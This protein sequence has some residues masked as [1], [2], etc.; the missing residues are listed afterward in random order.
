MTTKSSIRK[1]IELTED[2]KSTSSLSPFI[3]RK[4]S[5]NGHVMITHL[6]C[7]R[8]GRSKHSKWWVS[9]PKTS[10][11]NYLV[12]ERINNEFACSGMLPSV[13]K[14]FAEGAGMKALNEHA[15]TKYQNDTFKPIIQGLYDQEIEGP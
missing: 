1:I 9:S 12:N 8:L 2:H 11:G 15:R 10:N 13:Y 3:V 5:H 6:Y 4:V 14:R 7:R